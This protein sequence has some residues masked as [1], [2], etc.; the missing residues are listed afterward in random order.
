MRHHIEVS[1]FV[2]LSSRQL[3]LMA[4][5][6]RLFGLECRQSLLVRVQQRAFA[7][8]SEKKEKPVE[9]KPAMELFKKGSARRCGAVG[10]KIGMTQD[11]TPYGEHVALTVLQVCVD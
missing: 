9:V 8:T 2:C 6:F 1:K 7:K 10:V 4:A 5:T 11:F 3:I